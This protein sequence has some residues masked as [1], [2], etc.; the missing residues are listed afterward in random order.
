[1]TADA[2]DIAAADLQWELNPAPWITPKVDLALLLEAIALA[3][4]PT[5]LAALEQLAYALVARDEHLRATRAVQAAALTY[6]YD[7]DKRG[8]HLQQQLHELRA[9]RRSEGETHDRRPLA[10]AAR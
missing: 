2:S 5:I 8:K 9:A 10:Q 7:S 1:M 4:H 3:E 6:A